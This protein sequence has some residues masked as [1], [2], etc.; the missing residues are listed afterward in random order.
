M[1]TH[2]NIE[3]VGK[4]T[5]GVIARCHDI[6]TERRVLSSINLIIY[7]SEMIPQ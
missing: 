1:Y 7:A 3:L 6:H 2:F 4:Q 5:N